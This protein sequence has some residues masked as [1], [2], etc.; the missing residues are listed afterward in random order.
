MPNTY[1]EL[2]NTTVSANAGPIIFT[3]IPA[4]YTDLVLVVSGT[5]ATSGAVRIQFNNDTASN[6]SRTD[7]YG[8]GTS[9]ASYRE[10]NQTYINFITLQTTQSNSIS[11]IMNYANTTT[12][13]TMLTR[14]NTPTS[15]VV[16]AGVTLWR[17]TPEAIHTITLTNT[18][19]VTGTFSLYGIAKG[20]AI[21]TAAKATG[22]TIVFGVDGYTYH[23]FTSSGTFV[24]NTN[25]TNVDYLVVAGGG[26]GSNTGAG[27]GAGGLR[28]TM[29]QT[30]GGGALESKL[31]LTS[32]TSYT[33]TIGG[34][35]AGDSASAVGGNSVFGSITSLGGGCGG[36]NQAGRYNGVNGG[37]GGGARSDTGGIAGT[38]TT[39]QG[40]AGSAS[41]YGGGGGAGATGG[42]GTD[43]D[44]S[45]GGIG[46]KLSIVAAATGTGAS[47]YYA[48]GGSGLSS[49]IVV[50]GG[51]GGGGNGALY[52]GQGT[53]GVGNTGGGGGASSNPGFASGGSGIVIV[54]YPN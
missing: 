13:K 3:S 38:G 44:G 17:K 20:P 10:S 1:V 31:S 28:S 35:G 24:P 9:A 25:L 41:Q 27:G 12:H 16:A 22:G 52:P 53:D 15:G 5:Q 23:T 37:S 49:F 54:R 42:F 51:L 19:N 4:T 18:S 45:R 46:A 43:P 32:G 48:G 33:V 36:G 30:G 39:G 6:Y 40:F 11:H 21:A 26:G 2:A 7:L 14:Y 8:D 34:G 29:Y 47:G 50:P